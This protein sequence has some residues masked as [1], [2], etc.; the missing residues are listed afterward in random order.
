MPRKL[1]VDFT[2]LSGNFEMKSN[3]M[4]LLGPLSV[5]GPHLK[6]TYKLCILFLKI[7]KENIKLYPAWVLSVLMPTLALGQLH[8]AEM[9]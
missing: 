9:G 4:E 7:M 5:G 3:A 1:A 2:K 8:K 6:F